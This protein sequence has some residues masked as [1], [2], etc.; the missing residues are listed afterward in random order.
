MTPRWAL[1][2]IEGELM[3]FTFSASDGQQIRAAPC[4]YTTNLVSRVTT[5]L[6]E[7]SR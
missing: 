1:D 4:V 5:F 7:L 2:E 3:P 6:E